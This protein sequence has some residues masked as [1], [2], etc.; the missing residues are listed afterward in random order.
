MLTLIQRQI[1]E[2]SPR[3]PPQWVPCPPRMQSTL[4]LPST[5]NHGSVYYHHRLVCVKSLYKW[6]LDGT[7]LSRF[8]HYISILGFTL[9][10]VDVGSSCLLLSAAMQYPGVGQ[11]TLHLPSRP[12]MELCPPLGAFPHCCCPH[13]GMS[14][15]TDL[16]LDFFFSGVKP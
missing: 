5:G 10:L 15:C 13:L 11:T 6:H 2:E 9:V 14:F 8:C 12:V 7:P 1:N 4:A 16:G 3:L